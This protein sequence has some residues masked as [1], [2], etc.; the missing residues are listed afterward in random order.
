MADLLRRLE[1]GLCR[2][3]GASQWLTSQVDRIDKYMRTQHISNATFKAQQD[4]STVNDAGSLT[5]QAFQSNWNLV[6]PYNHS[7]SALV[8]PSTEGYGNQLP[9]FQLPQELLEDW[10]WPFGSMQT[11]GIFPLGFE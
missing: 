4:S 8:E 1:S 2:A 10:P 9:L 11:E 7:S 5:G 6:P 3:A